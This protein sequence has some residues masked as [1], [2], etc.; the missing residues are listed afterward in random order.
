V[1][2]AILDLLRQ[3]RDFISGA[4]ISRQF[5]VS[6]AAVW[7]AVRLLRQEGYPIEAVTRRGYR[8][9]GPEDVLNGPALAEL[10]QDTLLAGFITHSH[11]AKT[12]GSTNQLAKQ[13]AELGL[14]SGGLYVAEI[15]EAGRG[16]RGR[17]WL[18]DHRE[19]L[20]FSLLLRPEAAPDRLARV[21]LFSGLCVALAL[22]DLK[23]DVGLKWPNDLVSVKNGRKLGG[24]LTETTLEENIV[25]SVIIGIGLNIN[26]GE[27]PAG[28]AHSA[29]SLK[30]ESGRSFARID[31]LHAI[32][33]QMAGRYP[34]FLANDGWLAEYR[35][36]CLTLGR[37]VQVLRGDGTCLVGRAIDLDAAGE[38][39]VVD[40]S[41][42]RHTV[43]SGEVSVRG[44]A[45]R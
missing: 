10:A 27:F 13:A 41:G 9:A 39:I 34:S 35:Q 11:F 22:R 5:G 36:L 42:A 21:T 43:L 12:A 6:R 7:K 30:L 20:W 18:S 25:V 15:Q 37:E 2:D 31:V 45:G 19:G 8:L 4:L 29:T 24:I 17:T 33:R 38:L 44:P 3:N 14:P 26:T 32:L 23:I 16:R 28:L 1:K 40:D